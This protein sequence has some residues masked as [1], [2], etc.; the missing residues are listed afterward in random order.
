MSIAIRLEAIASRLEKTEQKD[1]SNNYSLIM[2]VCL[3]IERKCD[4]P[5]AIAIRFVRKHL[6]GL[7]M[8]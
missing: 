8:I 3:F 7:K 6:G 2:S 4:G 5:E 1:M